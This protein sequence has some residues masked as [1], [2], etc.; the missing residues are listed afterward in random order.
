M[1]LI[2]NQNDEEQYTRECVKELY[3]SQVGVRETGGANRGLQVERY[4]ASVDL[5]SGYAYCAAVRRETH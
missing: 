2:N 3:D 1:S 4:L 5:G